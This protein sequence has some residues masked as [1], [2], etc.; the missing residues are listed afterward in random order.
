MVPF[1]DGWQTS[2]IWFGGEE[3][4]PSANFNLYFKGENLSEEYINGLD[5]YCVVNGVRGEISL[6]LLT[7]V[8]NGFKADMLS[9]QTVGYGEPWQFVIG[10]TVSGT[11]GTEG[12]HIQ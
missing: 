2:P 10:E 3:L 6:M 7:P 1:A 5:M 9:E 8:G 12:G 11:M 4:N